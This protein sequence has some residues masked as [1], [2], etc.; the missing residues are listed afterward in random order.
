MHRAIQ[1]LFVI[2][3]TVAYDSS[4]QLKYFF[5]NLYLL[6]FV[7]FCDQIINYYMPNR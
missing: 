2:T 7:T 4:F 3:S 6:V 5:F 1:E